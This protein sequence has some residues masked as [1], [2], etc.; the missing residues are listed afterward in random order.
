V[1]AMVERRESQSAWSSRLATPGRASARRRRKSPSLITVRLG[2]GT[3][4]LGDL[5][6]RLADALP[7]V[8][9]L[10]DHADHGV[11]HG[12]EAREPERVVVEACHPGQGVGQ[13]PAQVNTVVGVGVAIVG[14]VLVA[15][16]LA[17]TF[18]TRGAMAG[19]R[20]APPPPRSPR[21]AGPDGRSG[22]GTRGR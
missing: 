14:L 10:D 20:E 13:A 7:G 15:T 1:L 2:S 5:R 8:A 22:V 9:S 19:N 16:G 21:R 4:D 3:P 17:V 12:R 6:R 18:A 11:G